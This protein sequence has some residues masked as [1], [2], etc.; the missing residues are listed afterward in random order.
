MYV[1]RGMIDAAKTEGEM[2]GVMA[3]EISHV[4]LRHATAQQTKVNNPWNQI[5]GIGA[6]VG[7]AILAGEAGAQ[8][9][10]IA[11]A[12]Y[13]LRY[14]REYEIQADTLGS[15]IMAQAGYDPR[16]LANMFQTIASQGGG[17]GPEWLSSHPDPGNRNQKINREAQVLNVSPNP[18]KITPEFERAQ[19]RLRRMS[20]ARSMAQ[21][22][23]GI[24]N[25][26]VAGNSPT[27]GGRYSRS[28]EFPSQRSR[29]YRQN[30]ISLSYP[31]NWREFSS[32]G[33]LI[34]AP[35][36]AYGD[37]GITH[38]AMMGVFRSGGVGT[39]NATQNYLS[40]MLQNNQYLSQRGTLSRA[41]VAG[42]QGY[43][44]ALSG[45]S[46]VTGRAEVVSIFTA[47]LRNGDLLYIA[48][49][50]PEEEVHQYTGAFRDMVAS[51]RLND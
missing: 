20:P 32:Q 40:S 12:G 6:V 10:Q 21:I 39:L 5:L 47:P 3:H 4:A 50:A 16:D 46:P 30:S 45:R 14:S 11:A 28:V 8:A 36:G 24:R 1:N 44:T 26:D 22:Q 17:R 25:G 35:E 51:I 19:A 13:F 31:D 29:V 41:T 7:G 43:A 38:G 18:L 48:A 49:V 23:Q 34:F 37:Q 2:A 15:Q 33:G 9:G 42:R 27:A